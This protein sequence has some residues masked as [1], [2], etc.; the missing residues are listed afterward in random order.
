MEAHITQQHH[1]MDS[2]NS[3]LAHITCNHKPFDQGV[4]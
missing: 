1:N 2:T 4:E 3:Q